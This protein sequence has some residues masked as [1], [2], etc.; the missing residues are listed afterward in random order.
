MKKFLCTLLS[1]V[2]AA[3]VSIAAEPEQEYY[4]LHCN[5]GQIAFDTAGYLYVA[6]RMG[7]QLCDHNG[8]VRAILPLPSGEVT[9]H[10]ENYVFRHRYSEV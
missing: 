1:G 10:R 3:A 2:L 4:W 6:T 7:V 5:G 9:D 8:R